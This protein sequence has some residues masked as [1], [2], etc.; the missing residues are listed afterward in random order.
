MIIETRKQSL[1][2]IKARS[3]FI[4]AT[5]SITCLLFFSCAAST[6]TVKFPKPS[7]DFQPKRSYCASYDKIWDAVNRVLEVNRITIAAIDKSSG[8]ITTDYIQGASTAY[9]AGLAGVGNSRYKYNIKLSDESDNKVRLS[10][11]AKLEQS[12]SGSTGST[13]YR[14]LSKQ[15][16]PIVTNLENWLYEQIEQTGDKNSLF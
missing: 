16:M 9:A 11:I 10:I 3:I 14:D 15:N 4:A 13:P 5:A 2:R 6:G 1:S 8:R 7:T 12:L